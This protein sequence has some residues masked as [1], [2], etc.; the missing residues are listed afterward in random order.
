MIGIL[1]NIIV[2]ELGA[3]TPSF[4]ICLQVEFE[5]DEQDQPLDLT[6]AM[7]DPDGR[8]VLDFNAA[9]KVPRDAAGGT[10][11]LFIQF[12]VAKITV[13]S[14]GDYRFEVLVGK[15]KIGEERLPILTK[16]LVQGIAE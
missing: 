5:P 13:T 2:P 7:I 3:N 12:H 11:R 1:E 8:S 15:R 10:T 16:N 14:P 6:T 9:G 4:F